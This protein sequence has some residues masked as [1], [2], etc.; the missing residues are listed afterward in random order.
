MDSPEPLHFQWKAPYCNEYAFRTICDSMNLPGLDRG[1]GLT[2]ER[3]A[4]DRFI[5]GLCN[6]YDGL[7][8]DDF[9]EKQLTG[10]CYLELVFSTKT[11]E[12]LVLLAMG[13]DESFYTLS[14]T[15]EMVVDQS[16]Y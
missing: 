2:M 6:N 7:C 9:R 13:I 11:K 16:S 8:V 5:I 3:W 15:G 4:R 12:H 1:S 10:E 14:K